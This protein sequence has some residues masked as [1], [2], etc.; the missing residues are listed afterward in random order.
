M[1]KVAVAAFLILSLIAG[2]IGVAQAQTPAPDDKTAPITTETAPVS[3][4]EIPGASIEIYD[5]VTSPSGAVGMTLYQI[6]LEPGTDI[7]PHEHFGSVTWYVDSGTLTFELFSGEVWVRCAADCV[8]GA[9]M[10]GSGFALVPEGTEVV[11]EAGDWIIQHDATIHSYQNDGDS[12]V[13]I[14]ASTTYSLEDEP[15]A[16]SQEV[17]TAGGATPVAGPP[18]GPRGC[19]GGCY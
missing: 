14:E 18:I 5:D 2:T 15:A 16:T 19:R 4:E 12:D 10:D 6:T 13:V 1:R 9:T 7:P 3:E 8:P 11:L 17:T